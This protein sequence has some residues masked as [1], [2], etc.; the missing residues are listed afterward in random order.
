MV[1]AALH[2]FAILL[3]VSTLFLIIA[4]A[5]VTSNQAGLSVPD[6]PLSYGQVMPEMEGGVFYEHGHRMI[7]SAVGFL[8]IVMAV[9]LWRVD[10]RKWLKNLGLLGVAAVILQGVLGGM[11]VLFMLPKSVSISHACLAQLFFAATVGIAIFTSPGW[12]RGPEFVDDSGWPSLRSLAVTASVL[13]LLQ[14]ALGAGFRHRAFGIMPHILVAL[15]LTVV[16]I[17]IATFVIVQFP[18]HRALTKAAWALM[19]VTVVQICLGVLAYV[20]RLNH[21]DAAYPTGIL[22]ASTVAHVAFGALTVAAIAALTLEI[23]YHVRPKAALE[24]GLPAVSR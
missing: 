8:T 10:D 5:S 24:S 14:V 4:G 11:T 2:R 3:A 18:K 15:V 13:T 12:R 23:F 22:V 19:G 7:A 17:M 16:L 6:W 9:W 20:V 21:W 1:Y